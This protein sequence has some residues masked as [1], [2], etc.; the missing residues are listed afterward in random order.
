M[1]LPASLYLALPGSFPLLA[2]ASCEAPSTV[3]M[4]DLCNQQDLM[5]DSELG[6]NS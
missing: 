4:A 1:K 6:H 3:K 5:C 2:M